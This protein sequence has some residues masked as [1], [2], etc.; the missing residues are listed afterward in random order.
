MERRTL[1]DYFGT[2]MAGDDSKV[3]F[4]IDCQ[5]RDKFKCG[6]FASYQ[7]SDKSLRWIVVRLGNL[8][9]FN[10]TTMTATFNGFA[11]MFSANLV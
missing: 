8:S 2:E 3:F 6:M 10:Y 1:C 9:G 7:G 5:G 4:F 11:R